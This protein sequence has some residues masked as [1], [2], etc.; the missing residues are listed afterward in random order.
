MSF[1]VRFYDRGTAHY[2]TS[3]RTS[4]DNLQDA[5]VFRRRCDASNSVRAGLI[6]LMNPEVI[7]VKIVEVPA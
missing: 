4:T 7:E 6:H 1:V 3:V 5:R 2:S